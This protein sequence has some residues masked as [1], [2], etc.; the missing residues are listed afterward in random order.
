MGGP[1]PFPGDAG[2]QVLCP[3][4]PSAPSQSDGWI[5]RVLATNA[6]DSVDYDNHTI[7]VLIIPTITQA[8]S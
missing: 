7:A 6:S 8:A 3:I 5:T 1:L 4:L 2:R